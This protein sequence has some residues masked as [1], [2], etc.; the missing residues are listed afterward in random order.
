MIDEVSQQRWIVSTIQQ[1][2]IR[3]ICEKHHHSRGRLVDIAA[4]VQRKYGC[5]SYEAMQQIAGHL[6]IRTVEVEGVVS[7]YA[8]LSETPQGEVVIRL[9]D[10]VVDRMLGGGE[11]LQAFCQ[12][13]GIELGQTTADGNISLQ[14]TPCI[15]MCDQAPAALIND[16]VVTELSSD[17]ARRIVAELR[18]S[19]DP[20][21]LVTKLGDGNNAHDLVHA[22]VRNNI[23]QAGPV[24][25]APQERGAALR[26]A[27]SMSPREVIRAMKTARL[28][29]R[30]GAGFPTGVKWE[31]TRAAV[32]GHMKY[33]FCNADEGEPGTFKDRVILTECP[34]LVFE[35]MAVAAYAIGASEGIV[36]LRA[37]YAYLQ[38]YLLAVLAQ[39]RADGLLGRDIGGK[40]G[41][42]FDVR[43]QLGS[44]AYICG[45]ESALLNS[46]EGRRGEPRNRPPYPAQAGYLGCPTCVNNVETLCAAA[47][48]LERGTGWF[49]KHG[50]AASAGTKLL[51]IS[52]DCTRPGIYELEFGVSLAAVLA[53]AGAHDAQAVQVGGPSGAL[54]PPAEFGRA[55]CYDD[56]STGGALVVFG[57]ERDLLTV[58]SGYVG[59]FA[60]ESCGYC[61]PCRVGTQL[62]KERIDRI[63]GG[64]GELADLDYLQKL[65]GVMKLASRCGLGQSA[66]NPVLTSLGGFRSHYER[67]LV[68]S[69]A[70]R[71]PGFDLE[72][73]LAEAEAIAG[74][75]STGAMHA[76]GPQE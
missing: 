33:V 59:F 30:G 68:Q 1:A 36:Y 50:S 49:T 76:A 4:A 45:E 56:I 54:V 46:A 27:L 31:L 7:F 51:S 47:R 2:T 15:G 40:E 66:P 17:Q 73:A 26:N 70:G 19:L 62:L 9:C 13:L 53:M 29:G 58:V 42:D 20:K 25:L 72:R 35:G 38:D 18:R 60:D 16:V 28:R 48:I 21:R 3:E 23:R 34:D 8:F 65:G 10:D 43:I 61:T 64:R 24:I 52:G 12:E 69:V 44:G 5:I 37:E 63:R 71:Q 11:V 67:Q 39:W 22:M 14:L 74:R 32:T 57:A 6:G 55:I 75:R 41:F